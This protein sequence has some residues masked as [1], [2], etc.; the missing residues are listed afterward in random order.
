M[1]R[2]KVDDVHLHYDERGEGEPLLLIMGYGS[3]SAGALEG[4]GGELARSFRVVVFDN[5]GT[6]ES[7]RLEGPTSIEQMADDAAG[8]LDALGIERSHV[9]GISMGGNIALELALRHPDK[10]AGLVARSAHCGVRYWIPPSPE[11]LALFEPGGATG[12]DPR[13]AARRGWEAVFPPEYVGAHLIELE[14]QL[15]RPSANPTPADTLTHQ[16]EAL[17]AWSCFERLDQIVAPT[18]IITGD[19]D[20]LVVPENSRLLH[21]RIADSRLHVLEGAAHSCYASHPEET[22]RVTAEFLTACRVATRG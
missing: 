6:G 13:E 11:I 20:V 1:P 22:V 10:V 4:F 19:R 9:V 14:A 12:L 21:E 5:R 16:W 2:I 7:D 15:D 17:Q 3:S 18:L 8:L